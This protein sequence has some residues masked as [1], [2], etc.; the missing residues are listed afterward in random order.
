MV[1]AVLADLGVASPQLDDPRSGFSYKFQGPLDMR[2]D[3]AQGRPASV[4]VNTLSERELR[5]ALLVW[6]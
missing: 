1:D 2:M 5:E 4:L 3:T 6:R